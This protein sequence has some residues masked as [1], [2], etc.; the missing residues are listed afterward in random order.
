MGLGFPETRHCR[1]TVS[2]S[3]AM[4]WERP[5]GTVSSGGTAGTDSLWLLFRVGI[6]VLLLSA[7][8]VYS[9]VHS[10]MTCVAVTLLYILCVLSHYNHMKTQHRCHSLFQVDSGCSD[11]H[12]H[13][14]T[15]GR[16]T[17]WAAPT[18]AVDS[19]GALHSPASKHTASR[20]PPN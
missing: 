16:V 1:S 3:W 8:T 4:R 14:R 9:H 6:K 18:Q 10:L 17:S 15:R 11:H 5:L 19:Q 20:E 2:P 13:P 7:D 12:L